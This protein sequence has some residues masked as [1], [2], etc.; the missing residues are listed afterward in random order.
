MNKISPENF[1]KSRTGAAMI[2]FAIILPLLLLLFFGITELGR[3]L[4]QQNA[5]TQAVELG[6]R[7]MARVE[8]AVNTADCT[9]NTTDNRWSDAVTRAKNLITCGVDSGCNAGD[10]VLPNITFDADAFAVSSPTSPPACIITVKVKADFVSI[11][12]DD[13]IP[14]PG[15]S[16]EGVTLN[17]ET[18]ER[19]IG[20]Y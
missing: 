9:A 14:V 12:G 3:A 6:G 15:F 18:Q 8:N 20:H 7:Y 17:A 11:F 10:S 4:Y 19:Y 13:L 16:V 5:L 1:C 2:E